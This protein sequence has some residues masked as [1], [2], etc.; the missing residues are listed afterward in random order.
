MTYQVSS[1]ASIA[2]SLNGTFHVI[3]PEGVFGGV[4]EGALRGTLRGTLG[5]T[6]GGGR[7]GTWVNLL[8]SM[9]V[10]YTAKAEYIRTPRRKIIS[11][12]HSATKD[13]PKSQ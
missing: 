8:C 1:S 12:N 9:A 11:T 2:Q 4:L 7:A 6:L 13:E 10:L 3:P 5:G